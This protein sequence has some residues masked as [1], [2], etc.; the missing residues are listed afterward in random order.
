MGLCIFFIFDDRREWES[1]KRVAFALVTPNISW[2]ENQAGS[3]RST[4]IHSHKEHLF[5]NNTYIPCRLLR[6]LTSHWSSPTMPSQDAADAAND[7]NFGNN[8]MFVKIRTQTTSGLEN[9]KQAAVILTAI[10]ETI[11]EQNEQLTPL[12]YFGALVSRLSRDI[13]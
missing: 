2:W 3:W 8:E 4:S 1:V 10:E 9:Q 12:A 11:R 6:Y 13:L 5:N 7:A